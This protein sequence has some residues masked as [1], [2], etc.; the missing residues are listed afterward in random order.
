LEWGEVEAKLAAGSGTII[1]QHCSPAGPIREWWTED[2][3]TALT[4]FALPAVWDSSRDAAEFRPLYDYLKVCCSRYVDAELGTAKLFNMPIPSTLQE[5]YPQAKVVT[6]L[7]WFDKPFL[8][9]GDHFSL[10]KG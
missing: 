7:T 6:L 5:K 8:F 1:I 3:L 9:A 10:F 4:P 2:D